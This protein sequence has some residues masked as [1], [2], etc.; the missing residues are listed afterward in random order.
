[1]SLLKAKEPGSSEESLLLRRIVKLLESQAVVDSAMRQRI[2]VEGIIGTTLG[3]SVTGLSSGAGVP[4]TNF[5][6]AGSPIQSPATSYWQNVWIGPVDQRYQII[7][8]AQANYNSSIR[9]KL[10]FT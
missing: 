2:V 4:S 9:N 8:A 7:D 6:T 1:M 10:S 5:P 3:N